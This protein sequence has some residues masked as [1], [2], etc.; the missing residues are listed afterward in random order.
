MPVRERQRNRSQNG[1]MPDALLT[2]TGLDILLRGD[3]QRKT[4][5]NN[6][7][8]NSYNS[9]NIDLAILIYQ[10]SLSECII[11]VHAAL[12]INYNKHGK[13]VKAP[14]QRTQ[15]IRWQ[16]VL[17][18]V[19]LCQYE[20]F[21]VSSAKICLQLVHFRD[22]VAV[23]GKTWL[24]GQLIIACTRWYATQFRSIDVYRSLTLI[25]PS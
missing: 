16:Q 15:L 8:R 11:D 12:V 1:E 6:S 18:C 13:L 20:T 2:P 7:I 5:K 4:K 21:V 9:G 24:K 17:M 23:V 14:T 25:Q 19:R 10:A 22:G 3:F